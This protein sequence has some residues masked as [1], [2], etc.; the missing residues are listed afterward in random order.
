MESKLVI[1]LA[2][3]LVSKLVSSLHCEFTVELT[4]E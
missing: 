4:Y 3:A 2:N 1:K